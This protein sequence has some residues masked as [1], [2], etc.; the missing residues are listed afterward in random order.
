VFRNIPSYRYRS[1]ER[2]PLNRCCN[3]MK[4]NTSM[5]V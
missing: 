2:I 5:T 4:M 1:S 3:Q